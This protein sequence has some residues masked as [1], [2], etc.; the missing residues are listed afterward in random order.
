[1]PVGGSRLGRNE[2]QDFASKLVRAGFQ[3]VGDCTFFGETVKVFRTSNNKKGEKR[4]WQVMD[5]ASREI[6]FRS[7]RTGG[8]L[9][10][11]SKL[12]I[13]KSNSVFNITLPD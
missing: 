10:F 6:L 5:N 1:M 2:R 8:I 4:Y 3:H 11:L 9:D 7:N 13:Y 12:Q